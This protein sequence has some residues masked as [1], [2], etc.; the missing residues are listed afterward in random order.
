MIG[1][2]WNA[3][4]YAE[5]ITELSKKIKEFHDYEALCEFKRL[6]ADLYQETMKAV[7]DGCYCCG[8]GKKVDLEPVDELVKNSRLYSKEFRVDDVPAQNEPTKIVVEN[9][10]SYDAAEKYGKEGYN[11]VV[12]N[13][14]SRQTAG[15]G[16]LRGSRAQEETLFRRSDLFM[17]LYQFTRYAS[18]YKLPKAKEQYPMDR[19][20]GG[21]YS[22]NITVFRSNADSGY[23]F[24]EKPFKTSVVSVAALNR[25]DLD[26]DGMLTAEM[27]DATLRKIRT[28]LRIGLK[29][30]HD[31][32]I[33]G[34][35]GCGAFQNP[36]QHVA[37]LFG[38]VFEETEFKNKYKLICFAIIDDHNSK[39]I[40]NF[41]PFNDYFNKQ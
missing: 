18:L 2:K 12:L 19:N 5:K 36:P 28:I 27:A 35:F 1:E 13:M 38:E 17:S 34:A 6:N 7:A 14:A 26:E 15:G 33:L 21:A 30:G 8:N 40:G 39:G 37:Q 16:V 22:P 9:M 20:F 11:T 41:K 3:R 31:C 10:D 24:L 32:I 23:E 25:P 29:H 4:G